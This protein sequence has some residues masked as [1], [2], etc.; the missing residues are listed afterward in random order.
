M[1]PLLDGDVVV[2]EQLVQKVGLGS[3]PLFQPKQVECSGVHVLVHALQGTRIRLAPIADHDSDVSDMSVAHDSSIPAGY[4]S[5]DPLALESEGPVDLE[6]GEI[7]DDLRAPEQW[8][9][10]KSWAM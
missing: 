7:I 6:D 4:L 5:S 9:S 8:T 2:F 3:L 1:A 10:L